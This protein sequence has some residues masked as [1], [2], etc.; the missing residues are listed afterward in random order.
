MYTNHADGWFFSHY[1]ASN[2]ERAIKGFGQYLEGSLLDWQLGDV[3]DFFNGCTA[4]DIRSRFMVADPHSISVIGAFQNGGA[5]RPYVAHANGFE[6]GLLHAGQ[7]GAEAMFSNETSEAHWTCKIY[8]ALSVIAGLAFTYLAKRVAP[9]G[10]SLAIMTTTPKAFMLVALA[11]GLLL[12][13]AVWVLA[14]GLSDW[15]GTDSD[16]YTIV[17]AAVGVVL[18]AVANQQGKIQGKML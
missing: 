17:A 11:S 15:G 14:Y 6:I 1:E 5:I 16:L 4:G 10:S 2:F 18:L 3:Y 9:R 13:A 12:V 7:H 8:R